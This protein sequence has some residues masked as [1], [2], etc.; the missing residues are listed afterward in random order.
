MFIS[1]AMFM[2]VPISLFCLGA[3][4]AINA[5]KDWRAGRKIW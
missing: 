1:L 5:W 3:A 4:F 2:M